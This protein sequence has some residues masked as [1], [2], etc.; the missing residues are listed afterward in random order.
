LQAQA[1]I[2]HLVKR[3]VT[4]MRVDPIFQ[5]ASDMGIVWIPLCEDLEERDFL[6]HIVA[7]RTRQRYS[8]W[9]AFHLQL[10]GYCIFPIDYPVVP[11]GQSRIRLIIHGANTEAQIDG[12]A[13]ATC[14]WAREMVD[15]ETGA[16]S[17][18]KMPKSAQ[19]VYALMAAAAA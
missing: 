15:I 14:E 4:T 16:D 17:R 8:Y 11:K 9:L 7:V 5:K 1:N 2:Q 18:T 3:F 13:K 10:L 12:I 19:H 6:V